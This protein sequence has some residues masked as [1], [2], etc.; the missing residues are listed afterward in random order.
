M[1][2]SSHLALELPEGWVG[3]VEVTYRTSADFGGI[4]NPKGGICSQWKE[5]HTA[6][7]EGAVSGGLYQ[8]GGDHSAGSCFP[9][10][11]TTW[12]VLK[13]WQYF[14]VKSRQ[15][16]NRHAPWVP[17]MLTVLRTLG[18]VLTH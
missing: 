8:K 17:Y 16:K 9:L 14:H 12:Y 1:L 10:R 18:V 2:C 11:L 3:A 6:G 13:L 5:G 15:K 4:R 7:S